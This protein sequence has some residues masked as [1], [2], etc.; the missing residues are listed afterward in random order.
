MDLFLQGLPIKTLGNFEDFL[1][2]TSSLAMKGS[3]FTGE[4]PVWLAETEIG[5]KVSL[6]LLSIGR[7]SILRFTSMRK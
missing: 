6:Q 4:M 5:G 1:S 2:I 3:F 7:A